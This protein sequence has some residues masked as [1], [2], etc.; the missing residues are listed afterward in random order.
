M[1][2]KPTDRIL[3]EA[4]GWRD[5]PLDIAIANRASRLTDLT[6]YA[7]EVYRLAPLVGIDPAIVVAQSALETGYWTS[8]AWR[9]RLNPAGIGITD[10]P[11]HGYRWESGTDA[12][13]G[14]V[15]HLL[16]YLGQWQW[17]GDN[18]EA[19]DRLGIAKPF[20]LYDPRFSAVTNAKLAGTVRTI[21]DLT[22]KWATDPRYAEKIA[23]RGNAIFP[24]IPDQEDQMPTGGV[25]GVPITHNILSA[26]APNRPGRKLPTDGQLYIVIHE[27]GN[28]NVGADAASQINYLKSAEAQSRS[29]SYH[30][31]VDDHAI[32]QGL[33]LD[34]IGW[35]AGDGCDDPAVDIGCFRSV[36]IETC[37]NRDGNKE[38][39]R[40]NLAELIARICAGDP[41]FDWGGG[42]SRGRFDIDHLAQHNWVSDD[43]KDCPHFIRAENFWSTLM[44]W[45]D[46]A[47][48]IWQPRAEPPEPEPSPYPTRRIPIP[49]RW[50]YLWQDLEVM[51]NAH[52][53]YRCTHGTTL[54]T[55]PARDAP[56]GTLTPARRGKT[57]RFPW[58][59]EYMRERWLGSNAG[60]WALA[61]AFEEA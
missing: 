47:W 3:G 33:P 60:S 18:G 57:Y 50:V 20:S 29:V 1:S 15:G 55:F 22:G 42:S 31:S 48:E 56:A 38:Q 30:L 46:E 7:A 37:V 25:V 28:T 43:R 19:E 5:F 11:D 10:G 40:R 16:V 2:M 27:T 41:A 23:E 12:A 34:E 36:A 24:G 14:Q 51:R 32:V 59:V 13:R 21:A 39:T 35:H 9:E 6:D 8:A 45:V 44:T 17:L 53:R 58:S 49:E 61:S 52:T 26:S 54:R 4:R